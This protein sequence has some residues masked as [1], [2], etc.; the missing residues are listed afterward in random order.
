VPAETEQRIGPLQGLVFVVELVLLAV[1][2]VA[3]A[4][5]PGS[6]PASIAL[7]LALPR[8]AAVVWGV[9]LAPRASHRLANPAR[10]ALKLALV[11]IAASLLAASGPPR[12][13]A[14]FAVV[15]AALFSGG[16]AAA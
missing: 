6:T 2:A 3:G 7:A 11:A 5:L 12:W 16:E 9:Q 1:L 8:A 14:A 4:G 15:A 13:A 10:L